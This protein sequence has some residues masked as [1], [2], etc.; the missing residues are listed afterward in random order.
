[1]GLKSQYFSENE[2]NDGVGKPFK[3][4]IKSAKNQLPWTKIAKVMSRMVKK[5]NQ[6]D[7]KTS[8]TG[9]RCWRQNDITELTARKLKCKIYSWRSRFAFKSLAQRAMEEVTWR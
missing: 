3:K 5:H 6:N 9:K 4:P 8:N 1:M 2:I 7:G